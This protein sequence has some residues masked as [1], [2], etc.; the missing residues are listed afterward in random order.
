[1]PARRPLLSVTV[2]IVGCLLAACHLPSADPATP[3]ATPTGAPAD[4]LA[5]L[6]I[7][8]D[9]SMSGYSRDQFGDGWATQ[10]DHCDSRVD[11]LKAQGSGVRAHGC[12]VTSGHWLSLYD[13]VTVTNPHQ[14]DIDHLVPLAEAW[15]TGASHWTKARREAFANDVTNELV[16]VTAHSN[17][18]KGDDPPPGYEPPNRAEDCSYA[19]RWIHVK[20]TYHLTATQQEHD[21][22]AAMLTTC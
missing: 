1:M 9:G 15:R 18:S 20:V 13:G 17:R 10:A 2:V 16:A 3:T 5:E 8:P 14:L 21:A 12:T 22:L 6:S 7:A 19:T 11:V 4:E